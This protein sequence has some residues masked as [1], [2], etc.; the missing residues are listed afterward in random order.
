M[1]LAHW[2]ILEAI[3]ADIEVASAPV[4]ARVLSTNVA[5]TV[6]LLLSNLPT[7]V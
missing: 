7:L 4:H 1:R 3:L 5:T 2:R 6:A